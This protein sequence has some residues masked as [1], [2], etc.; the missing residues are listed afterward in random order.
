MREMHIKTERLR[1]TYFNENI[2]LD[3]QDTVYQN[4]SERVKM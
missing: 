2:S 1:I 3:L 4:F